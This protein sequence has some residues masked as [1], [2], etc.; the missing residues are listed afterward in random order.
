MDLFRPRAAKGGAETIG[1]E[2]ATQLGESE[3]SPK[4]TA[5]SRSSTGDELVRMNAHQHSATTN[6]HSSSSSVPNSRLST[7]VRRQRDSEVIRSMELIHLSRE[8]NPLLLKLR[9][10]EQNI[11]IS[12]DGHHHLLPVEGNVNLRVLEGGDKLR[13]LSGDSTNS[14]SSSVTNLNSILIRS[15]PPVIKRQH[16][17]QMSREN[18]LSPV[19]LT[20]FTGQEVL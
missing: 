12:S 2:S 11:A 4:T 17:S 7:P 19:P 6:V 13:H 9:N 8:D 5:R 15:P 3:R 14:D 18:S 1:T 16:S 20:A 10:S